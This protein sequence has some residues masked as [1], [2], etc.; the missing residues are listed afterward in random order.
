MAMVLF[1]KY[2][3][4]D[5]I[6]VFLTKMSLRIKKYKINSH[7]YL[8]VQGSLYCATCY[9]FKLSVLFFH[10]AFGG[11]MQICR[12]VY[13]NKEKSVQTSVSIEGLWTRGRHKETTSQGKA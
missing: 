9:L 7:D 3:V 12:C 5:I 8:H 1:A 10:A 13:G 6:S 2:F 11:R 4:I